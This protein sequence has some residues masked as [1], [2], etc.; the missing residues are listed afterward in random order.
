MGL[1]EEKYQGVMLQGDRHRY[2][3]ASA[4]LYAVVVFGHCGV[5]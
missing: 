4:M 1:H 3:E 2:T 5:Y